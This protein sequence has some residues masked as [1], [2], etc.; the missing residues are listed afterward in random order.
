MNLYEQ[1]M[2]ESVML[3][4]A[5]VISVIALVT[6]VIIPWAIGISTIIRWIF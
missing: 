1:L 5:L 3:G 4:L 2:F 6:V